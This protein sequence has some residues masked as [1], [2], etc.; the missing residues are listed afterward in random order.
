MSTREAR[1]VHDLRIGKHTVRLVPIVAL[2]CFEKPIGDGCVNDEWA[3]VDA[4]RAE[5]GAQW[6]TD[7][8]SYTAAL[9]AIE[10]SEAAA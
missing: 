9:K 10:K 5:L 7:L 4:W 8:D 1:I 6:A 2:A 3:E